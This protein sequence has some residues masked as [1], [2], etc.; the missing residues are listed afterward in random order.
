MGVGFFLIIA[1]IGLGFWLVHVIRKQDLYRPEPLRQMVIA[2]VLGGSISVGITL[3]SGFV[4]QKMGLYK[5]IQI[6]NFFLFTGPIEES[7]K[8]IG[9]L[10]FIRFFKVHFDEPV[11]AVIYMSCVAL[12]FSL[13]ENLAY[14][15][16]APFLLGIRI[17]TATPMH[18]IFSTMV[19]LVFATNIG[20]DRILRS[21]C[22][23]MLLA[24]FFHGLFDALVFLGIIHVSQL[25]VLIILV[26]FWGKKVFGYT[27]LNSPYRRSMSAALLN[28]I[29]TNSKYCVNCDK[30]SIH[31]SYILQN[32]T[33]EEC[34]S[35]QSII[36]PEK[37]AGNFLHYFLPY[38]SVFIGRDD[39][40]KSKLDFF[41]HEIHDK[42]YNAH[43]KIIINEASPLVEKLAEDFRKVFENGATFSFIFG[44]RPILASEDGIINAKYRDAISSVGFK[45]V[46]VLFLTFASVGLLTWVL[47]ALK[48][49]A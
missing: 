22:K 39:D 2:T 15:M 33:I 45:I 43:R 26:I 32:A 34:Q 25:F 27:L 31:N 17:V 48:L 18:I 8:L 5:G 11:D 29:A 42:N 13:L 9:F 49:K 37:K 28:S 47:L 4:L 30:D 40:L 41:F 44:T 14:A 46:M 24:S 12:G 6:L 23:A 7:S 38:Y 3:A 35:C 20:N 1:N 16:G 36:L 10:L 19:A 21:I